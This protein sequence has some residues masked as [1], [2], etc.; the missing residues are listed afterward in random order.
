LL[1]SARSGAGQIS[2]QISGPSSGRSDEP[3]ARGEV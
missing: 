1:G 2:G 3:P